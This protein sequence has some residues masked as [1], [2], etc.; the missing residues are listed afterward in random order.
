MTPEMHTRLVYHRESGAVSQAG[1]LAARHAR[2][3]PAAKSRSELPIVRSNL[4]GDAVG[5]DVSG[6]QSRKSSTSRR[7]NVLALSP[8]S[9]ARFRACIHRE[10]SRKQSRRRRPG[11]TSGAGET[12]LLRLTQ[13][14]ARGATLRSDT[15]PISISPLPCANSRS[16]PGQFHAP[17]AARLHSIELNKHVANAL[18]PGLIIPPRRT[19]S[20]ARLAEAKISHE[21]P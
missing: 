6:R 16:R 5:A 1:R 2:M 13:K 17:W 3:L 14:D 9:R 10:P 20:T 12:H 7:S 15:V 11:R 8:A 18:K 4:A 21:V 19:V